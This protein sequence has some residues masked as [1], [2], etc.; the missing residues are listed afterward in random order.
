MSSLRTS[1]GQVSRLSRYS[2]AS[3]PVFGGLSGIFQIVV[4]K[5]A[6]D[7]LTDDS[8][9]CFSHYFHK[10]K[11]NAHLFC[12]KELGTLALDVARWVG[13]RAIASS[14]S[15]QIT[16]TQ[17]THTMLPTLLFL[18]SLD[19]PLPY[20]LLSLQKLALSFCTETRNCTA[21]NC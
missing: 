17:A 5:M 12:K 8:L 1:A 13:R 18:S 14:G 11:L 6:V 15:R 4:K 20:Y 2:A 3:R 9:C 10:Q 19:P 21:V 16:P 7:R